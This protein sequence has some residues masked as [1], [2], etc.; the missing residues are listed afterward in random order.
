[1]FLPTF[2]FTFWP[3][4]LQLYYMRAATSPARG[5]K[6]NSPM[7]LPTSDCAP[8]APTLQ[9]WN[10]VLGHDMTSGSTAQIH[11]NIEE[12]GVGG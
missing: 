9:C 10:K 5:E 4:T 8:L 3:P 7:F 11:F 12:W 2:D 1:M 6:E